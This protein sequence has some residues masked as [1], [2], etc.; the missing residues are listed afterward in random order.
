MLDTV[1]LL[2]I[3]LWELLLGHVVNEEVVANLGIGILTFFMGLSN[4]LGKDTW[5]LS[6]HEEVDAGELGVLL[7]GTIPVTGKDLTLNIVRVNQNWSP[8]STTVLVLEETF[9]GYGR[10]VALLIEAE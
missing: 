7:V 8:L 3:E 1:N 10:E 2:S 9:A 6:I 5:I 4:T